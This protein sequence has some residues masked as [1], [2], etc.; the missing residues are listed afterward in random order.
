MTRCSLKSLMPET[1]VKK[2]CASVL[3]TLALAV[4]S[5]AIAQNAGGTMVMIAQPEPP[6]LAP[7]LST[8]GPIGLVAPK[9]YSGLLD[10]DL[11]LNP[12]GDLAESFDISEDG[13]TMTFNLRKGV[14]WHD[15]EPFTSADV[16]FSIMEV[17]KKFHPRGPNTFR[18]VNS[19]DTPDELTAVFNLERPAPYMLRAFSAYES[20]I[21]PK[22]LLE[23]KDVREA[24][25]SNNPVGTGPFKFVEWKK[26]QYI[27]LDKNPDYWKKGYP[28]LDRI[29]ARVIPDASTRTAAMESG[30]VHYGAFG[31]IPNVDVIRLRDFDEIG[32]TTDGYAMINPMALIEF[33]VT[34]PPFDSKAMRQA[35][36]LAVDRQFMIDN[37]WFGY[38]KP[39]T[40]AMT[41]NYA[42]LGLYTPTANY[43]STA[44][45]PA[46]IALLDAAGI[47]PDA[48]GV[49]ATAVIDLIPYGE[50]WRRVGEYLKQS[51]G[52]IGVK[53]ELRYEDVPTWLKRVYADYDFSLNIN[54]FY[55]LP[56]PVI[57]VQRHYGTDQI[58]QGTPFV[59]SAR[60]S[61]ARVDELLEAGAV[62][63]N[64]DKRGAIYA[65]LQNILAD[66]LPVVNLFEMEFLTVYSEKLK[67]HTV[68]AMG[69]YGSFD[70]AYLD[71]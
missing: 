7:Y 47:K 13:K 38:G 48:D 28:L 65:E 41:S 4:S 55:Q 59:N 16:Q 3:A 20:P 63:A 11:Q 19:I 70:R 69:P 31:A 71:K 30:E 57:G 61:N 58:R 56:D 14:T 22:H 62:E 17:L 34:K 53:L 43:P 46:A 24:D 27:R 15:G 9:I 25:L 29:V 10:Y 1:L 50:E 23:G 49:R 21:V 2:V 42:P 45:V 36:S 37:I 12:I 68:S 54:Y 64:A 26:G 33:D 51:L 66:E 8:S 52:D 60:Y 35:I 32:V 44:D 39:A 18:E 67:D 40:S 6:S 5:H